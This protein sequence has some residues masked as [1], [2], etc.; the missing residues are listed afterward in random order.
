M[1]NKVQ[2]ISPRIE[3]DINSKLDSPELIDALRKGNIHE[4]LQSLPE[5]ITK[6]DML[7]FFKQQHYVLENHT[8]QK[9]AICSGEAD[10]APFHDEH[11]V[12]KF[13][14]DVD[15]GLT[16]G[17]LHYV[18]EA[19][20]GKFTSKAAAKSKHSDSGVAD[21]PAEFLDLARDQIQDIKDM[22]AQWE[23]EMINAQMSIEMQKNKQVLAD[24]K[25]EI[26]QVKR[27]GGDV[28]YLLILIAKYARTEA[29]QLFSVESKKMARQ[30]TLDKKLS[31]AAADL[32]KTLDPQQ[33]VVQMVSIRQQQTESSSNKQTGQQN[34]QQIL[35]HLN[36][37][38]TFVNS[39]LTS[40]DRQ[41]MELG[42]KLD[43]RR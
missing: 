9:S 4:V 3:H 10:C 19:L 11:S 35:G 28:G 43:V 41:L 24:I 6:D 29:G 38:A 25:R 32:S 33:A 12:P 23:E 1:A 15:A 27:T 13:S 37:I 14:V 20:A 26:D 31:E 30:I 5:G 8:I 36:G 22:E 34:I 17:E 42:R 7:A 39:G 18:G 40:V 2:T 21:T 16:D